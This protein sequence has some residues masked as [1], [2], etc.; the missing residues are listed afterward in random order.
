MEEGVEGREE[1]S[2]RRGA[3]SFPGERC[4]VEIYCVFREV[5][6]LRAWSSDVGSQKCWRSRVGGSPLR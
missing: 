6:E 2:P 1:I 5:V 3:G 4:E